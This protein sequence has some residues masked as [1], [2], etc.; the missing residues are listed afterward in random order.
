MK[1]GEFDFF[2]VLGVFVLGLFACVIRSGVVVFVGYLLWTCC[3]I[4]KRTWM[5]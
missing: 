3:G 5:R 1:L 2:L 4:V